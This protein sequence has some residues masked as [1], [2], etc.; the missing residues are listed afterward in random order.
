MPKTDQRPELVR[1]LLVKR[2]PLAFSNMLPCPNQPHPLS[3]F[4]CSN[5]FPNLNFV[6]MKFIT[7]WLVQCLTQHL[8]V[9]IHQRRPH[10]SV[11]VAF[12]CLLGE[13]SEPLPLQLP[14]HLCVPL[15]ILASPLR[16]LLCIA[17][18]HPQWPRL[19]H[20]PLR[21]GSLP[22]PPAF[23]CCRQSGPWLSRQTCC[24]SLDVW[25]TPTQTMLSHFPPNTWTLVVWP[26]CNVIERFGYANHHPFLLFSFSF[27]HDRCLPTTRSLPLGTTC[28]V[29]KPK[30]T[31]SL[32]FADNMP[33]EICNVPHNVLRIRAA[34]LDIFQ[35]QQ[36]L[37]SSKRAFPL[38]P[39]SPPSRHLRN[40]KV[41]AHPRPG[42][43]CP[44]LLLRAPPHL[45]F[46]SD[47]FS[48]LLW[49][50]STSCV[51]ST[52]PSSL[53]KV[54]CL[55]LLFSAVVLVQIWRIGWNWHL[56]VRNT[57]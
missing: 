17:R 53:L 37:S 51:S 54:G 15:G 40:G 49:H 4:L 6:V 30:W 41:P 29:H 23:P 43:L 33:H 12:L 9:L 11:S 50:P 36:W 39:I 46:S 1:L 47:L 45:W 42:L 34:C 48:N 27:H 38:S 31:S 5:L 57:N 28:S 56:H 44:K 2:T 20:C 19:W 8:L 18:A 25:P 55:I 32:F 7:N 3:S 10:F 26:I 21:W 35:F 24:L 22:L 14:L 52:Q 16:V 13:M